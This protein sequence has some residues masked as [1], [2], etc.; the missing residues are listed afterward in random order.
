MSFYPCSVCH[1]SFLSKFRSST[2][3]FSTVRSSICH[4]FPVS[5]SSPGPNDTAP[6]FLLLCFRA[7][8]IH[9]WR[10]CV[11]MCA[12]VCFV[13]VCVCARGGAGNEKESSPESMQLPSS[14]SAQ[15]NRAVSSICVAS[16]SS[17]LFVAHPYAHGELPYVLY[18]LVLSGQG[19]YNTQLTTLQQ[20]RSSDCLGSLA[21]WR[22]KVRACKFPAVNDGRTDPTLR[23][24]TSAWNETICFE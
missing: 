7:G 9:G 18:E 14:K 10:L 4:F 6:A 24:D 11:R 16:I 8:Q 23:T 13:C 17:H 3:H 5:C 1:L 15:Y 20:M 19:H 21:H 12:C 2:C 22:G